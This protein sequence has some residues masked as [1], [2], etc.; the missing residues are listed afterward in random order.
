MQNF[1]KGP[2]TRRAVAFWEKSEG[3]PGGGTLDLTN[4]NPINTRIPAATICGFNATSGLWSIIK[5]AT[6]QAAATNSATAYPV[7]KGHQ[8]KVGDFIGLGPGAKSVTISAID[9]TNAA[10]DTITVDATLGSAVVLGQSLTQANAAATT[11]V[12]PA[13]FSNYAATG[14]DFDFVAGD[15]NLMDLW[16]RAT[17]K[18]DV[19]PQSAGLQALLS[20]GTVGTYIIYR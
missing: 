1:R 11:S 4:T 18:K 8:F 19:A 20:G 9:T 14:N 12:L 17:I 3:I 13:G 6:M 15:N 7:L 16:T 2:D 10:Y 5:A